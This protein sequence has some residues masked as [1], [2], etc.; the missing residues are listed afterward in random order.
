MESS[1]G[2]TQE[3]L[4]RLQE[5]SEVKIGTTSFRVTQAISDK[6]LSDDVSRG[7][8]HIRAKFP[9]EDVPLKRL[10]LEKI[11]GPDERSEILTNTITDDAH[12]RITEIVKI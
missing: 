7:T 4:N 12:F 10:T 8:A 5:G 11:E 1:K 2:L 3:E 9:G 6:I